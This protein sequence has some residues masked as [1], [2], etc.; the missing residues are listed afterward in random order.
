MVW[1]D[2]NYA[3][4]EPDKYILISFSNYSVP[5]VGRY[6][7]DGN[8]GAFYVGDEDS[9]CSSFGLF[10]NAWMPLPEPYEIQER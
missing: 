5:C 4:P 8:G 6:E 9:S 10:V 3:L 2:I 7:T 1:I